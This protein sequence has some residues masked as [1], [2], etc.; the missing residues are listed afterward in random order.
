M[1]LLS[2]LLFYTDLLMIDL[3]YGALVLLDYLS[4]PPVFCDN[5]W[6]RI[7]CLSLFSN[8]RNCHLWKIC[9]DMPFKGTAVNPFVRV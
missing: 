7:F 5:F 1:L 9:I 2:Y 8:C 3:M 6:S 4:I